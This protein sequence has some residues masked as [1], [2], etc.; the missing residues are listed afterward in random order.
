MTHLGLP[1][2]QGLYDPTH[3]HDACG[4]GFV[5]DLKNRKSHEIIQQALQ[6][7]LS[8]EHRGAC[9]CEKNTGDGAGILIQTPHAFLKKECEKLGMDL[10]L[11]GLYGVG[12]VFLPQDVASRKRCVKIFEDVVAEEGQEVLGWRDVPDRK[13]TRLNSSHERLSRMP[14]S[15]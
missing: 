11:P 8:L 3:E 14:S 2:K 15:A 13:S 1:P 6:I 7:L 5:V 12:N 4:M 10:P 9:G